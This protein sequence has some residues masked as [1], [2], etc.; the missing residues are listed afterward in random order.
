[1]K[2]DSNPLL[3][4]WDGPHG[5]PPF[6]AV[7]PQHFKPAFEAAFREQRAEIEAIAAQPEAPGFDNSVAA[8]DASGRLLA[9]I[10]A[11][12]H[13]LNSSAST[14]ELQAVEREMAAPLAAHEHAL[15]MHAGLFARIDAVHATRDGLGLTDE[16]RRLVE[17]VHLEFV[18]AGARLGAAQ[19]ERYGAVMQRLA[20]LTTRFA[21]N[22][23]ADENAWQLVLRGEAE[24]IG[25]AHV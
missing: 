5:L 14:P 23:L 7:R 6:D 8:F 4:P 1:M 3:M 18:R 11:L 15:H 9:R 13:N 2:Q 12:F 25:R 24:Q 21:Q 20:E 22:V 10:A 19:R 16:Q 17:R